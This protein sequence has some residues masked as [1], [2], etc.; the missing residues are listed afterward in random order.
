MKKKTT[1]AISSLEFALSQLVDEPQHEDEFSAEE[2]LAKAKKQN[3][4]L[5]LNKVRQRLIRMEQAGLLTKRTIRRNGTIV[6][7][8]RKA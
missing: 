2:A 7:L 5:T 8:Y 4:H 1:K 6:S 3:P